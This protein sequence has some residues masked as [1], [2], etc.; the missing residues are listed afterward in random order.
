MT[1]FVQTM[2]DWSR[3]CRSQGDNCTGC[4]MW[5][6]SLSGGLCFCVKDEYSEEAIK[7]AEKIVT[8]WAAE[9]PEPKYPIWGKYLEKIIPHESGETFLTFAICAM[10]QPI[11]ADIAQKL[12]IEP[13]EDT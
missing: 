8:E 1:D 7:A 3:M 5:K 6:K 12:G 4:D 10:Q 9:H 2:R 11:P 13:M